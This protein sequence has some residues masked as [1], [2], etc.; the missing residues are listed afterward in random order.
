[1]QQMVTLSC[2]SVQMETSPGKFYEV[3]CD[4]AFLPEGVFFKKKSEDGVF[5]IPDWEGRSI[6]A[7]AGQINFL[8]DAQEAVV[9]TSLVKLG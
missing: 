5:V 1:M 9:T 6:A 3:N 8:L 4:G 2:V 7:A